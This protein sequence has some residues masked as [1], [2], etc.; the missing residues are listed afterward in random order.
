MLATD[1]SRYNELF[2]T[3]GFALPFLLLF[4]AFFIRYQFQRELFF[5]IIFISWALLSALLSEYKQLAFFTTIFVLKIQVLSIFV[6]LRCLS[7]KHIYFYLLMLALGSSTIII[8]DLFNLQT[9]ALDNRFEGTIGHANAL[10]HAAAV[11]FISWVALF[12]LSKRKTIKIFTACL[13]IA[14]TVMIIYSGSRGAFISALFGCIIG[15][16][17]ISKHLKI[18]RRLIIYLCLILAI[19]LIFGIFHKSSLVKRMADIPVLLGIADV[20]VSQ[21]NRIDF[22]RMQIILKATEYFLDKPVWGNGIGTF[23]KYTK[24]VYTHTTPVELLYATGIIGFG[25]YYYIVLSGWL[26]IRKAKRYNDISD[27]YDN[28]LPPFY[29]PLFKLVC[30]ASFW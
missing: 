8:P 30:G 29:V 27:D 7:K 22:S 1:F 23:R 13:I 14:A 18:R 2:S 24:F 21:R 10:G 26:Q 6:A 15:I 3:I 9:A 25:L 20:E 12:Y 4:T 17:C 28:D 19:T 5:F 11:S 16:Y